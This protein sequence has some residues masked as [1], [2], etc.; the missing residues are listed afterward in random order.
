MLKITYQTIQDI[1]L[2]ENGNGIFGFGRMRN[3]TTE[4][5]ATQTSTC[6][7]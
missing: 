7:E 5:L 2:G 6:V 4:T 3:E 1:S